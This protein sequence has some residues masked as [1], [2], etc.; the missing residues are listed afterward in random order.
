MREL[1]MRRRSL[2]SCAGVMGD[3]TAQAPG[4]RICR[5]DDRPD[6]RASSARD[7]EPRR[8][9]RSGGGATLAQRA[10]VACAQTGG[11]VC[12]PT[13]GSLWELRKSTDVHVAL[14]WTR[15]IDA[16]AGVAV[17]RTRNLDAC[18]VVRRRDG[19][20]LTVPLW[21][22]VRRRRGG[23]AGGPRID[24]RAGHRPPD[25]HRRDAGPQ[26]PGASPGPVVRAAPS[27]VVCSPRG[28]HGGDRFAP[29]TSFASNAACFAAAGFRRSFR[30]TRLDLGDGVVVH[31]D[32][33]IPD[34]R[35]YVEV[36]HLTWHG[37]RAESAYDRRR[38]MK[39]RLAGC[40]VERVTDVAIDGRLDE[41]VDDL[42]VLWQH[43]RG[44][45]HAGS[46][47]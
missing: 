41:V 47:L 13:A 5:T 9:G 35:F 19:I 36:D 30:G 32:L 39:M 24:D 20:A 38:D 25:V 43:L 31:P 34:D 29:T 40:H 4:A 11:V 1:W 8:A 21:D 16:P 14:P 26:R 42:W 46:D 45:L 7:R 23:L 6:G 28:R 10:A 22:G 15:R 17:H 3:H 33:G 37:G 12:F 2:P 18:D 44:G 27:S